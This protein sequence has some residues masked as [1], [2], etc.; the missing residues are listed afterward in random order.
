MK[1]FVYPALVCLTL[2]LIGC[3]KLVSFDLHYND[4]ITIPANS[5]INIPLSILAVESETNSEQ[6]LSSK[7]SSTSL[8]S[9]VVLSALDIS[10]LS[11]NNGN[12]NFLKSVNVYISGPSL[13]ETRIAYYDD[14]PATNLQSLDLIC[15]DKDLKEYLKKD[16][17]TIRV[18]AITDEQLAQN[19][20][21]KV[22]SK[23]TVDAGIF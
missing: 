13:A 20:E 1:H 23:L 2:S 8:I 4:N 12:F 3:K 18:Q 5:I 14:V 22:H 21:V 10:I 11:P 19:T 16:T 6:E 7:G 9:K 17:Y 15:E